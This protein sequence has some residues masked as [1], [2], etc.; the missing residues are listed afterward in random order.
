MA[1]ALSIL[2]FTHVKQGG[3]KDESKNCGIPHDS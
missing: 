1:F 3:R 2:D